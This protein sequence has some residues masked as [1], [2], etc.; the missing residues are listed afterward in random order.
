M[1]D[2]DDVEDEEQLEA[3]STA[4]RAASSGAVTTISAGSSGVSDHH[5][6]SL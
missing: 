4:D 5:D 3:E 6:R 1:S 2:A